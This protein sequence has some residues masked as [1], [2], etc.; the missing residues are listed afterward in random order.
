MSTNTTKIKRLFQ[1]SEQFAPVTLSEAVV[2]NTKYIDGQDTITTLD[3]VLNKAYTSIAENTENI[4]NIDTSVQNAVDTINKAIS[5]FA[6]DIANKQ[7]KLTKDN[8]KGENG[9]S[10][11]I[12]ETGVITVKSDISLKLYEVVSNLPTENISTN[13]IYIAKSANEGE[14]DVLSEYIW[15]PDDSLE[16]KGYW[17]RLGTV[18][19]EID[20]TNYITRDEFDTAL[21]SMITAVDVTTSTGAVVVVNYTIPDTLYD[22]VIEDDLI[23]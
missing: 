9:I 11:E 22:S 1:G 13:T 4:S 21:S 14:S 2:V 15:I 3:K 12:S 17:E 19:A 8:L 16:E 5:D 18:Q 23:Q 20:L 10:I 7:D 6:D